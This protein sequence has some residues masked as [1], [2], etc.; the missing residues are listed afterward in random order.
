[1]RLLVLLTCLIYSAKIFA[2]DTIALGT[3]KG[4]KVFD[5]PASKVTKLYFTDDATSRDVAGCD[6]IAN[7][8]HSARSETAINQMM[9]IAIAAYISGKKIRAY[10]S[11]KTCEADFIALQESQF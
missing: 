5:F 1:M 8:T 4:I 7:I 10:S 6:G 3:L 11:G 9:S 2:G